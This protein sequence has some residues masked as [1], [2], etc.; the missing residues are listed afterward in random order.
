[1]RLETYQRP[2][3][4]PFYVWL[5]QLA[6][7]RMIDTTRRHVGAESRSV[8]REQSFIAPLP[9]QSAL[10]LAE[11]LVASGTNAS[12]QLRRK[13]MQEQ[14][15][16]ALAQLINELRSEANVADGPLV[17]NELT[18]VAAGHT[19]I[20]N[21]QERSAASADGSQ[22]SRIASADTVAL[23]KTSASQPL[24]SLTNERSDYPAMFFRSVAR[25]GAQAAEGLAYAHSLGVT[26]RDIK[27][28]NLLLDENGKPLD[29]GLWLGTDGRPSHA[30]RYGRSLRH[31][32]L[33]EPRAET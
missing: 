1:M 26:H 7:Q 17:K 31:A 29:H 21:G 4:A 24:A 22:A 16:A 9:D 27:P 33:H 2:P 8:R 10:K 25:L 19:A 18:P 23:G 14:V 30:H 28:G 5:R 32:P 15:R 20:D 12:K 6:V 13:E 11:R 3:D